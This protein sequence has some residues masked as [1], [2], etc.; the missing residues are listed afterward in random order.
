MLKGKKTIEDALNKKTIIK[1]YN[2]IRF[3][4]KFQRKKNEGT[5]II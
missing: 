4:L 3:L 5:A 1:I 2:I